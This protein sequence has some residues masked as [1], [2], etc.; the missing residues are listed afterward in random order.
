MTEENAKI[1]RESISKLDEIIRNLSSRKIISQQK[2]NMLYGYLENTYDEELQHV[3]DVILK[4]LTN[5]NKQEKI[6]KLSDIMRVE[7]GNS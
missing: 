3:E 1:N 7:D 6:L 4:E 5:K 2:L